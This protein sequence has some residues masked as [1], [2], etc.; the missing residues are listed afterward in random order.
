MKVLFLTKYSS[1]GAS[2]RYRTFQYL[3]KLEQSG[4]VC[5][6]SPLFDDAYLSNKYRYGS[7]TK[8]DMLRG[9]A[10]RIQAIMT[11][12]RY[13]LVVVEKEFLPYFPALF[14]W[15]FTL[16]GG[17]YIVDYDD[18]LFHQYDKHRNPLVRK[19]LGSKISTVMRLSQMVITGNTYLAN[20]A[21]LAGAKR[22]EIIPT[23][24]DLD[25]YSVRSKKTESEVL[26]IGWIGS[27]TTAIYLQEIASVLANVCR[28]GIARVQ[29]IGSGSVELAEIEPEILQWNDKTEAQ[30]MHGFDVGI[31]PLPD[32]SWARG[33]CGFKLIQYMACGLPVIASPVGVNS[34]IVED[35]VNGFL[36]GNDQE[37]EEA[38]GRL[39]A[40]KVLRKKMGK[41]GRAKVV[42][43][44]S[45]QVQAP[46]LVSLISELG[47]A[48]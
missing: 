39:A 41:R 11:A 28:D 10:R 8:S 48:D 16:F 34:Q 5:K 35:G 9:L 17:R 18:A 32:E 1:A 45:L 23:V 6:V 25:R 29:L 12:W 22:V 33:K 30:L 37:W 15:I 2:S 43:E 38:I 20:Y 14:E 13:D 36:A 40:D 44:Y 7:G 3:P 31:M 21:K 26:T 46:R 19:L 24:I 4:V 42:S 27:P 47:N